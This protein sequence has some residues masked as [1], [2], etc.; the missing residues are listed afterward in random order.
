ML[1]KGDSYEEIV[2]KL[3]WAKIVPTNY[4]IAYSACDRHALA[5]GSAQKPAIIHQLH[6]DKVNVITFGDLKEQSDRLGNALIHGLNMGKGDRVGILLPQRPETAV[7]HMATYKAACIA[8]PLFTLFGL[9]ALQF[10]LQNSG[11]KVR[12]RA[13]SFSLCISVA[14]S[15]CLVSLSGSVSLSLSLS[16]SLS[17][18]CLFLINIRSGPIC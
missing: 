15:L 8:V 5:S 4:N 9:E 1:S 17:G 10:R 7:I 14:F 2:A 3:D 6:S 16:L 11:C 12:Q 13:D 18:R